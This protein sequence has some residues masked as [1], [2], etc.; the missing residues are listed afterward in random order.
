MDT[1]FS[2][3]GSS[4]Y[5]LWVYNNSG[6]GIRINQAYLKNG[7]Q[8]GFRVNI[9]GSYLDNSAG[10]SVTDLEIRKG[11]S[12][13][14]FVELTAPKNM[15]TIAQEVNDD[16][17]FLLESG[18]EQ[19]ITLRCYA[20]DAIILNSPVF[21]KDT[22]IISEKPFVVY[23]QLKVE[24]GVTLTLKK[25][26]LFFHDQSGI[27]VYGK[28]ITDSVLMRGDR[29]DHMFDYL[30]Y[31]RVSGQWG[32]ITF[33]GTSSDNKMIHTELHSGTFGI[34]CDSAAVN[35]ENIRLY[36][37]HCVV[38]NSKGHG[39]ELKNS[40]VSLV[41]C[42]VTN[43]LGDCVTIDGGAVNLHGC[44]LGQF[45][46]FSGNRGVALRFVN[47]TDSIAH[48]L[49][50]MN[51]KNTIITGY[52]DDELMGTQ[53]KEDVAFNYYFENCL[54]RTPE[55]VDSVHFKNIIWEKKDDEIQGKKHFVKI[56][57]E[58][59]IYDF[60]LDSLSTAKGKGCY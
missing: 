35:P 55:I 39:V 20:W 19:K 9:D 21:T 40:Y 37:E 13:R 29:L 52:A 51:C 12:I 58:N 48:A 32:G 60:H 8:T 42:Q 16:L 22:T 44:T 4:T 38:H 33:H 25:T 27:E 34:R 10:S 54:L 46:P 18:V 17:I 53:K 59:F 15:K 1:V 36:M 11:D 6:D 57:E 7:N 49:E 28:L 5:T 56:D 2:T 43:S 50:Q 24:T 30:P 45:Y 41:S 26:Q 3:I 47:G 14:V 31:D 23:G